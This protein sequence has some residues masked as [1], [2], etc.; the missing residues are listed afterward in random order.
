[1]RRWIS[2]LAFGTL[3]PV[4]AVTVVVTV[5]GFVLLWLLR[6]EHLA[7]LLTSHR[8]YVAFHKT[9]P[10]FVHAV[11]MDDR[12]G[13][14]RAARLLQEELTPSV[15][16]QTIT[17]FLLELDAWRQGERDRPPRLHLPRF[18]SPP[19]AGSPTQTD[20]P[21][22]LFSPLISGTRLARGAL[23]VIAPLS[24]IFALLEILGVFA[25]GRTLAS[26]F[27]RVALFLLIPSAPAVLLAALLAALPGAFVRHAHNSIGG[28]LTPFATF[29][30]ALLQEVGARLLAVF[31]VILPISL[32]LFVISLVLEHA[33][34]KKTSS[35]L[36]HTS[37]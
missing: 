22:G 12:A 31:L 2:N 11:E 30:T 9:I 16:R 24:L 25:T 4:G 14:E 19:L 29:I 37:A 17:E 18:S 32:A 21:Q 6:P 23:R 7:E 1:M 15:Y 28:S 10:A 26:R 36:E 34:S 8:V 5:V 27:R 13:A 33:R 35:P 20:I 3:L